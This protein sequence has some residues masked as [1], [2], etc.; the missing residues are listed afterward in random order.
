MHKKITK[1]LL[2][3]TLLVLLIGLASATAASDNTTTKVVKS[4]DSASSLEVE[5]CDEKVV[6]KKDV[7]KKADK[8][9]K[10][11]K[12]NGTFTALKNKIDD[13]GEGSLIT[14]ENDYINRNF[15][16]SGIAF[17]K[18]LTI[19]GKGHT[20]DASSNSGIF[21]INGRNVTIKNIKFKNANISGDGGAIIFRR[22]NCSIINSTF[23]N[24]HATGCGGAIYQDGYNLL[25]RDCTF[26][27]NSAEKQGG[28]IYA[29]SILIDN[30]KFINNK[31]SNSYYGYK[32]GALWLRGTVS[33]NN[34]LFEENNGQCIAQYSGSV[35]ITK[36]IFRNNGFEQQYND[37]VLCSYMGDLNIVSSEFKNNF[38]IVLDV[39]K[40]NVNV[41]NSIFR[42]HT[43]NTG[44][45]LL[46][47]NVKK[48]F[49]LFN[50]TFEYNTRTIQNDEGSMKVVNNTFKNNNCSTLLNNYHENMEV[51]GNN[52][53]NNSYGD[54]IKNY[55]G[56]MEVLDNTF[57]QNNATSV[58]NYGYSTLRTGVVYDYDHL[59]AFGRPTKHNISFYEYAGIINISNNS[60]QK[61]GKTAISNSDGIAN[62]TFNVFKQNNKKDSSEEAIINQGTAVIKNNINDKT[63]IY[64]RTIYTSGNA[65]ITDNIF[66]DEIILTKT[67]VAQIK[68]I[69]GETIILRARVTDTGNNSVS[70]GN[71]AFK[72]NGKTLR[73]DGRFD[74]NAPAMKF[75]VK[76]GLV[77]YTI[78]ADL[79]LRN[80]K[81]L[82]A[83]YSGSSKYFESISSSVTAQIQKRNAQITVIS[84][85]NRSKQYDTL[86]FKVTAKDVTKNAK[87]STL[88]TE[89]TRVM[90]KVN[91]VT[92]KDKNGKTVYLMLDKNAQATYKY[93]I[94]AGTGGITASKVARNYKVDAIFVGENYYPGSRNTTTFQV[95]RSTT[96]VTIT[97]AKVSVG[98]VL[99]VKATLKDYKGNNLIG[100][101]KVSIKINGKSYLDPGN[102]KPKYWSV[103]NGVVDLSG[104]TV[105]PKTIIKR[106]MIVTGERQA[107]TEGRNETT[108][109]LRV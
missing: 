78:K 103:K 84:T 83:S 99:S 59:D 67:I 46:I 81:N 69:I 22:A 89:D 48:E 98:N 4:A 11:E 40:C 18:S 10:A 96:R 35:N 38:P 43:N 33:I 94:P 80:A 3:V 23:I 25:I 29:G 95:E 16:S 74:S 62:I 9:V 47:S 37:A 44:K 57:L 36:S 1:T 102:G 32:G 30:S 73:G 107:Y 82:T 56:N 52:F 92:L 20:I 60:F 27:N 6:D 109:I 54:I 63:S 45:T 53:F 21:V 8:V 12:D 91:G 15:D 75:S 79:Y 66:D 5:K 55:Q 64:G 93:T 106:V 100:T 50:N 104:I 65:T 34:T 7:I 86:T 70:G 77:E 71:L 88:I 108:N 17:S 28:A 49:N 41:S 51:I 61:N 58:Y 105:N 87:N 2:F 90:L 68:G 97:Q 14:L 19:D 31:V 72:L 24:N 42:N 76:N 85:P 26:I 39:E 13:A 101:N